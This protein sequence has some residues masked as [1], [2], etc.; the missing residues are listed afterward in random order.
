VGTGRTRTT[1][2]GASGPRT[3]PDRQRGQSIVEFALMLPMLLLMTVGVV[4]FARAFGDHLALVNGVREGALYGAMRAVNPPFDPAEAG[5]RVRQ[6]ASSAGLDPASLSVQPL[7]CTTSAAPD[8]ATWSACSGQPNVTF[9]R[10]SAAYSMQ[11]M[12]PQLL[13]METV[14]MS[15]T[16]V[17]PAVS[18]PDAPEWGTPLPVPTPTDTPEPEPTP[19]DTPTPEPAPTDTPSPEP[20]PTDTPS[21]EPVPT[22]T[23]SPEPAPTDTPTPEPAPTDTPTPTPTPTEEPSPTPTEEAEP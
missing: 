18:R 4:D 19:T 1:T 21:P 14:S 5:E 7:Q 13:G 9:V 8:G 23:P 12:L 2:E 6:E 17:A 11:L 22:D 16:T 10:M 3:Q 20:A 15:A